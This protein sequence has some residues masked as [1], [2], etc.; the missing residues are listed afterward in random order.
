M[1]VPE[2]IGTHSKSLLRFADLKHSYIVRQR[3]S[4]IDLLR[5]IQ[6]GR[7]FSD[8]NCNFF[9]YLIRISAKFIPMYAQ[10]TSTEQATSFYLNQ[11]WH[12]VLTH[13]CLTPAPWV[14]FYRRFV[15]GK[16]YPPPPIL[17][18][19]CVC[20]LWFGAVWPTSFR[21]TSLVR[22][23]QCWAI[24]WSSSSKALDESHDMQMV[25][26]ARAEL[27]RNYNRLSEVLCVLNIKVNIF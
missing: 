4:T 13:I 10:Q 23:W 12:R 7:H 1:V 6:I 14:K 21:V 3:L 19:C 8:E 26:V 17:P 5:P 20:L 15:S 22:G 2:S 18:L 9:M 16:Y 25:L 11:R 27:V 24:I